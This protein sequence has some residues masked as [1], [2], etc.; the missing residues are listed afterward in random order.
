MPMGMNIKNEEA[1]A[2]AREIAELSGLS[3][4]EAVLVA[5]REKHAALA[6]HPGTQEARTKSL[7]D[8][9]RR[10]RRLRS[11]GSSDTSNLYDDELGLPR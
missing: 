7:L 11:G 9:G 1:H 8:Y 2:L 6:E 10:L 3:L 5:L 4:T